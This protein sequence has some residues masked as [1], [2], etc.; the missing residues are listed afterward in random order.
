[1]GKNEIEGSLSGEGNWEEVSGERKSKCQGKVFLETNL[2]ILGLV[3][4]MLE[5][6]QACLQTDTRHLILKKK[7][8]FF[9]KYTWEHYITFVKK[10]LLYDFFKPFTWILTL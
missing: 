4:V 9:W 6:Q 5:Y 8:L 7:K 2:D 3:T 1:M 10:E